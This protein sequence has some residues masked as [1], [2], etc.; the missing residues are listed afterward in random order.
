MPEWSVLR[1]Q[2]NAGPCRQR[3]TVNPRVAIPTQVHPSPHRNNRACWSQLPEAVRDRR[4]I[5]ASCRASVSGESG[6]SA[7]NHSAVDR[8]AYASARNSADSSAV[9]CTDTAGSTPN[10]E[11]AGRQRQPLPPLSGR[12]AVP[13]HRRATT[14]TGG[15]SRRSRFPSPDST[16]AV[17]SS[18]PHSRARARRAGSAPSPRPA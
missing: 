17:T 2:D 3:R 13:P 18:A 1:R 16:E 8:P 4:S 12:S 5:S 15:E 10:V 9:A 7:G 11:G 14:Q 6:C